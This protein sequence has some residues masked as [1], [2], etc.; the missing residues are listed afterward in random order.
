MP[1]P[2]LSCDVTHALSRDLRDLEI[3][4]AESYDP[5]IHDVQWVVQTFNDLCRGRRADHVTLVARCR[6]QLLGYLTYRVG[7]SHYE[8]ARIAVRPNMR[9]LGVG[10]QLIHMMT[11]NVPKLRDYADAI[12]P[13]TAVGLCYLLTSCGWRT[14]KPVLRDGVYVGGGKLRD[15]IR[16][17]Y[18]ETWL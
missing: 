11:S 1:R 14:L 6:G 8:L 2:A 16:F 15:G 12:V 5:A 9:R 13:E 18:R 3:M 10:T 7:S 4:D 17:R